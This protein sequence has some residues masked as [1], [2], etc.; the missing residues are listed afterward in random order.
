MQ[1]GSIS[2]NRGIAG[3]VYVNGNSIFKMTGG[4]IY[5]ENG[6][7]NANTSIVER[8]GDGPVPD[9]HAVRCEN[10]A[11]WNAARSLTIN[12]YEQDEPFKR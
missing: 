2:R 3:G 6:G 4:V 9:A 7:S 10:A 11:W 8:I 5:G 1:G 12:R